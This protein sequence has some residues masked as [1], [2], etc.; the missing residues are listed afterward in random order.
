[1]NRVSEQSMLVS[2]ISDSTLVPIIRIVL[3]R[4]GLLR[5]RGTMAVQRLLWLFPVENSMRTVTS[6]TSR[7]E[8]TN[9]TTRIMKQKSRTKSLLLSLMRVHRR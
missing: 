5:R 8:S 3:R 9:V 2:H 4:A 7:A 1:M 6:Q